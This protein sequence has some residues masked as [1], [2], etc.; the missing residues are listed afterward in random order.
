MRIVRLAALALAAV[1]SAAWAGEQDFTLLNN[2]GYTIAELYVSPSKSDDWEEDVLGRDVLAEAERTAV[3]FSRREDACL[4]DLKVVYADDT[5][6][7]WQ[8]VNLC[9]VSVVAL[10]YDRRTG[11]TWADF[12]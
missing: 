8:G 3:R 1:G 12:D 10:R 11:E 5:E 6:S 4:W 9:E 2:T 7:Q